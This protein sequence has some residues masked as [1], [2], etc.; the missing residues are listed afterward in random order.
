MALNPLR[1]KWG[2]GEATLN[3]WLMLPGGLAAEAMSRF[4][5]DSITVDMQHGLIGYE[6]AV[7]MIIGMQGSGVVPMVRVPWLDTGIIMKMLDAGAKG[8]ICPMINNADEVRVLIDAMR[9]P[10]Q[11][12]RSFGPIRPLQFEGAD[13]VR[14]ANSSNLA[15]AMI[16]TRDA[17][18]NLDDILGVE[19]L[20]GIYIGPSDLAL[21]L[22]YAPHFDTEE[23]ELVET[24][25]HILE[26]ARAHNVIAG[27]HTSSPQYA[28]K[29]ADAGFNLVT[30]GSDYGFL[31]SG[32]G[33]LIDTFRG[34]AGGL[35]SGSY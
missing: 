23:P 31:T 19:G 28:R 9:Y 14:D 12:Q 20:D 35:P 13:Y 22:G 33:Q 29:M 17:L 25:L 24:T 7:A 8:I 34:N 21:V 15:F 10:P 26:R 32:A 11:G 30:S 3:G 6:Q 16:E 1:E 2:A 27:I 4:D 18:D 5:W